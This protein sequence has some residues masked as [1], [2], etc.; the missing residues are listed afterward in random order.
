MWWFVVTFACGMA[1]G[2]LN[3]LPRAI[4]QKTSWVVMPCLALLVFTLGEQLGANHSLIHLLPQLGLKSIVIGMLSM[5]GSALAAGFLSRWI[6]PGRV[7]SSSAEGADA[8]AT[9]AHVEP[10]L[11]GFILG[12]VIVGCIVGYFAG[13]HFHIPAPM[14]NA[15]FALMLLGIGLEI[16][17][18]P[19]FWDQIRK[20]SWKMFF[21]PVI[22]IV[23]SLA[24]GLAAALLLRDAYVDS[25][26]A[27]A[28]FGWYSLAG[29]LVNQVAGPAAGTVAFLSNVFRE[30]LCFVAI[31]LLIR[32]TWVA[33]AIAT[34]G[35][36]TMDTTLALFSGTKD[37]RVVYAFV[38]GA[39]T[40]ALVPVIIPLIFRFAS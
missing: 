29:I 20:A 36:T 4:L 35:A 1:V 17:A 10:S 22:S 13:E 3:W 7:V 32:R 8:R 9:Q 12:M 18:N 15:V 33:S 16:G 14:Q 39:M 5:L 40:S 34:G 2:K 28:G 38:H 24:G 27:A 11:P 6:L 26:A 30:L 25:V 37:A 31:P 19:K 23:G 21:L